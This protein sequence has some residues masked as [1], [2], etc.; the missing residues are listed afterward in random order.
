M[1]RT[2][3]PRI[4]WRILAS[5]AALMGMLMVGLLIAA[6]FVQ[7]YRDVLN[8]IDGTATRTACIADAR[9]T[10]DV[11]VADVLVAVIDDDAAAKVVLRAELVVARDRIAHLDVT[12]PK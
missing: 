12:C 8:A 5:A 6:V 9:S 1:K 4:D 11:A 2:A 7:P 10:L 3:Q